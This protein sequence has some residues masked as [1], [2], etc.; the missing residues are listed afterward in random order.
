MPKILRK[1]KKRKAAARQQKNTRSKKKARQKT[2]M[3]KI[4]SCLDSQSIVISSSDSDEM[5]S[6]STKSQS[7]EAVVMDTPPTASRSGWRFQ[8]SNLFL[9]YPQNETP[10]Q[11]AMDNLKLK[12]ADKLDWAVVAQE[13]HK[14]QANHLHLLIKL[15]AKERYRSSNQAD[16]DTLAGAH[17]NYQTARNITDVLKYVTKHGNYVQFNIVVDE[18]LKARANKK[19][20]KSFR[21]GTQLLEDPLMVDSIVKEYPGFMILHGKHVDEFA[22]RVLTM[23]MKEVAKKWTA[24]ETTL[25]PSPQKEIAEWCNTALGTGPA[26]VEDP[27]DPPVRV[28]AIALK[29][30]H[31]WLYGPTG[32]G[33]STLVEKLIDLGVRV[34][35]VPRD[36]EFYD[37]YMDGCYDL[38]VIDEFK[39]QKRLQWLNG[40]LD[41]TSVHLRKKGSQYLKKQPLYTMI[42][43]NYTP[44]GCYS[45][46][47]VDII[48]TLERRVQMVFFD[49]DI[50]GYV[51]DFMD[52]PSEDDV[53][54][55]TQ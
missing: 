5:H 45:K 27:P 43:S 18:Y 7:L 20:S 11:T 3:T 49:P 35:K 19:S 52:P 28:N 15:K 47:A 33:K 10:P 46:T 44:G 26:D 12:F 9:T 34:Y 6:N 36:E 53:V 4:Q 2:G 41:G 13:P 22:N 48:E 24:F 30:K 51:T 17:G 14:D 25:L 50:H 23:R 16:L 40:W 42:L 32:G 8:A 39:A 21:I 31:L 55:S 1:S 29:M 37:T 38:A 54:L